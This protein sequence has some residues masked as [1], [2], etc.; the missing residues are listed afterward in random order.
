LDIGRALT[1]IPAVS[2]RLRSFGS[3]DLPSATTL[4]DSIEMNIDLDLIQ[5]VHI[6]K[7][8]LVELIK[9]VYIIQ[10]I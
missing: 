7:V 9:G 8:A 10:H 5:H 3:L 2:H 4:T 6:D 1:L